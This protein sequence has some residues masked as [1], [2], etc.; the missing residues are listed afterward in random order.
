MAMGVTLDPSY[1]FPLPIFGINYLDFEFRGPDSQLAILFAGVLAAGNVQRP[2]LGAHAARRE[3]GLLRHRRA[4]ERSRLRRG[5][6]AREGAAAHVAAHYRP[7]SRL[8]VHAVPET[9][10]LVPV[11]VRRLHARHD[12]VGRLRRA[13]EHAHERFWWRMGIPPRRLQRR[14]ERRVVRSGRV[15]R[16]GNARGASRRILRPPT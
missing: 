11:P 16:M 13:G 6:R 5:G 12:D 9:V 4:L 8:A 7:E 14:R 10:G 15:A 3:R 2:K 1:A